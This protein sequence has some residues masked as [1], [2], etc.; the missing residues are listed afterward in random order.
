MV[1]LW[2]GWVVVL[3]LTAADVAWHYPRLPERLA[4]HFNVAGAPDGW[5]S[6]GSFLTVWIVTLAVMGVLFPGLRL[7]VRIL[8]ARFVNVPR[9]DYWFAAGRDVYT[10]A[11]IGELILWLGLL[12]L[13]TMSGLNHLTLRANLRPAPDLGFWPWMVVG[14]N[15]VLM[16]T[17]VVGFTLRFARP[18]R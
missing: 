11:A 15:L 10:R 17:V 1:A 5:S 6:R 2:T 8:P 7:L 9:R 4:T 12:M 13:A 14:A 16:L 18:P 3:L